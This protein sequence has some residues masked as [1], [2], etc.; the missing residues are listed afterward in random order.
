MVSWFSVWLGFYL[1]ISSPLSES[2]HLILHLLLS[3]MNKIIE[4]CADKLDN[5]CPPGFHSLVSEIE[6][7]IT[8][9]R[10]WMIARD[11]HPKPAGGSKQETHLGSNPLFVTLKLSTPL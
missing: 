3:A 1:E 8:H 11:E 10:S 4:E 5:P 2:L 9:L 7:K 6:T